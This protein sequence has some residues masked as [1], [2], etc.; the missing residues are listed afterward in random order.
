MPSRPAQGAGITIDQGNIAPRWIMRTCTGYQTS[1][2]LLT[3]CVLHLPSV[4]MPDHDLFIP[5]RWCGRHPSTLMMG[6]G[7]RLREIWYSGI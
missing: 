5:V 2:T 7:I 3:T 1:K 4:P 6:T